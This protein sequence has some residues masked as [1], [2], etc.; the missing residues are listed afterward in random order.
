MLVLRRAEASAFDLDFVMYFTNSLTTED[1]FDEE[2]IMAG[3]LT[4]AAVVAEHLCIDT[5]HTSGGGLQFLERT[6]PDPRAVGRNKGTY[7]TL[8]DDRVS[9]QIPEVPL[10]PKR[11]RPIFGGAAPS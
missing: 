8:L 1:N 7:L 3:G 2:M 6:W 10:R 4:P 9:T 11:R 5:V